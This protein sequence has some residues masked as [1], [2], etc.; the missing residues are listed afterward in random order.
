M[1]QENYAMRKPFFPINFIILT[2]SAIA[3]TACSK[4]DS[5]DIS[6]NLPESVYEQTPLPASTPTPTPAPSAEP[7]TEEELRAAIAELG[8]SAASA[9]QRREY[10][11]RLYAMDLFGENDYLAL[12]QI[13]AEEGDWRLQR[14]MLYKVLRLYPSR[15]YAQMLSDILIRGDNSDPELSALAGQL[16]PALEQ[17]DA[18]T[19]LGLFQA[20]QWRQVFPEAL[21]GIGTRVQYTDNG[22][23]LQISTDGLSAELT[24]HTSS[25]GFFLCRNDSAGTLLLSASL[26][27][28]AYTGPF[29]ASCLDPSG[30][31]VKFV[32]GTLSGGVCIDRLIIRYRGTEYQGSFDSAGRTQEEQLKEVLQ[33]G[34]VIYAYDLKKKTYLYQK[35]AT[36][37]E[38]RIDTAF[39]G[40]PEYMEWQ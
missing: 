40:L 28:N 37:E 12:A 29:S 38:F 35:D 26:E 5:P 36:P 20:S 30:A 19:L 13:Y 15:E 2:V 6:S 23:V 32:Q 24:W 10:Y 7:A 16:I 21:D 1:T 34:N 3:F 17:Q 9:S 31:E 33:K 4:P 22:N 27:N 14:M 25:G 11:E 39:L 8:T 18:P